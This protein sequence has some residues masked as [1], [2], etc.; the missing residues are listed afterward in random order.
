MLAGGRTSRLQPGAVRATMPDQPWL[1]QRTQERW[2]VLP[3]FVGCHHVEQVAKAGELRGAKRQPSARP[4][5]TPHNIA[6]IPLQA[7][8]DGRENV[9]AEARCAGGRLA[10]AESPS[11]E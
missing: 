8:A 11:R 1:L 2:R 9:V 5:P 4:L 7:E 6:A 3:D 10:I